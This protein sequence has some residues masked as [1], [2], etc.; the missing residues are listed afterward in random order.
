[1]KL[2]ATSD[3]T[4][5]VRVRVGQSKQI[6]VLL[7]SVSVTEERRGLLLVSCYTSIDLVLTTDISTSD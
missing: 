1:M 7:L 4:F 3:M 6:F 2:M 5:T